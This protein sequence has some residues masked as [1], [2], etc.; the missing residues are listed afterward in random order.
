VVAQQHQ[1]I[2]LV[3]VADLVVLEDLPVVEMVDLDH[4]LLEMEQ[5]IQVLMELKYLNLQV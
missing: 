4:N 3:V 1:D 2:N 5:E